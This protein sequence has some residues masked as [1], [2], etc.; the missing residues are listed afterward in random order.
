MASLVDVVVDIMN[1][2]YPY[3]HDKKDICKQLI[4]KEEE[5]FLSTLT[6][7]EKKLQDI[8]QSS[9]TKVINGEDAFT[10]YDTYGFPIELTI[11]YAEEK[12]F[13]VDEAGFKK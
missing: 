6:Q 13:K 3:L 5:K 9:Q 12:G 2:Y 1:P 11:E 7:G 4:T 10:L 8:C